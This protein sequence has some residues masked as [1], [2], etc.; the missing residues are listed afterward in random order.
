MNKHLK[1]L[2][3]RNDIPNQAVYLDVLEAAYIKVM[4]RLDERAAA[5][6]NSPSSDWGSSYGGSSMSRAG[7]GG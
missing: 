7:M 1:R 5:A 2:F 3:D 4:D 6:A